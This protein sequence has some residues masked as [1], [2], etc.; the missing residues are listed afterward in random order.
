MSVDDRKV[1]S[2][3]TYKN[4]WRNGCPLLLKGESLDLV[5]SYPRIVNHKLLSRNI[6]D[7]KSDYV[8]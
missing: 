3:V 5:S 7:Y 2:L 1:A 4:K 8:R 6:D